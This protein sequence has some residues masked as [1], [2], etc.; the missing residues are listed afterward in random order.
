MLAAELALAKVDVAVLSG[1]PMPCSSVHRGGGFSLAY[2]RAARSVAGSPIGSSRRRQVAQ[3]S[4]IGTT[5][6]DM[7][8]FPTRTSL[9]ARNLPEQ[10]RADHGR[11]A[12]R[13]AVKGP[14]RS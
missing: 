12:R 2:D 14:L 7:S 13:I 9:F 11:L 8:D 1:D 3:A 6:L 4:M 10:D 5:V